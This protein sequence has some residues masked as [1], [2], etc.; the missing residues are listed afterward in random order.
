VQQPVPRLGDG[1]AC[2][3]STRRGVIKALLEVSPTAAPRSLVTPWRHDYKYICSQR[4]HTSTAPA[5]A[6]TGIAVWR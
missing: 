5:P 3:E 4:V 6:H 1:V 2:V